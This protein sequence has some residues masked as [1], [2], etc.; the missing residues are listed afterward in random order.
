MKIR[1]FNESIEQ[2]DDQDIVSVQDIEDFFYEWTDEELGTLEIKD[3]LILPD[4]RVI[5][6]TPYIKNPENVRNGKLVKLSINEKPNGLSLSSVAGMS[7]CFTDFKLLNKA[8][9]DIKRFYIQTKEPNINYSIENS[10]MGLELYFVV[11][12]PKLTKEETSVKEIDELLNELK[13]IF[14]DKFR[15][16][17]LTGN[18]LEITVPRNRENEDPRYSVRRVF[19]DDNFI[20]QHGTMLKIYDWK[21]KIREKGFDLEISGG[22]LQA[23]FKL[24]KL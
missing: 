3:V 20:P 18:W 21:N 4:K 16:I 12:G 17:K 19:R 2:I 6:K 10:F 11:T 9:N 5:N 1:K 22:D 13:N 24:K 7:N 8:V 23:V 14:K 15:K